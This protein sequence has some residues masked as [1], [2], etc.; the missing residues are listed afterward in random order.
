MYGA[1]LGVVLCAWAGGKIYLKNNFHEKYAHTKLTAFLAS[2]RKNQ[3][4]IGNGIINCNLLTQNII[5]FVEKHMGGIWRGKEGG[6]ESKEQRIVCLLE[7][8]K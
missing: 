7:W 4:Q 5:L 3:Q 2:R 1:V 6:A 8:R